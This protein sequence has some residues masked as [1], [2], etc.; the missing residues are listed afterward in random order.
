MDKRAF[1]LRVGDIWIERDRKAMRVVWP[2]D[3]LLVLPFFT[4]QWATINYLVHCQRPET[5]G[6][7]WL[8]QW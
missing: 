5:R 2:A 8:V 1:F 6:K 3:L 4:H 7:G